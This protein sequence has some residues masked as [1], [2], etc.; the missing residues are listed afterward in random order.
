MRIKIILYPIFAFF[1][2]YVIS[3]P[4]RVCPY[5]TYVWTRYLTKLVAF[6]HFCWASPGFF[7]SLSFLSSNIVQNLFWTFSKFKLRSSGQKASIPTTRPPP[8]PQRLLTYQQKAFQHLQEEH[9]TLTWWKNFW[10]HCPL[11]K[12]VSLAASSFAI[13]F[14]RVLFLSIRST[15]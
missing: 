8:R 3:F 1:C 13:Q 7:C 9:L 2:Y 4:S 11:N 10:C 5:S 12:M 15:S 6:L 14:I